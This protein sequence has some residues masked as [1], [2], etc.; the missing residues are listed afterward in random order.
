MKLSEV[1]SK[2]DN[3][4]LF[5]RQIYIQLRDAVIDWV[6]ADLDEEG[7]P[8]ADENCTFNGNHFWVQ[9]ARPSNVK[10][11]VFRDSA[12]RFFKKIE[13]DGLINELLPVKFTI[14]K[15]GSALDIEGEMRVIGERQ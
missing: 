11:A 14:S 3:Q 13:E 4:E 10:S 1:A 12:A 15:S 9:M 5:L 6:E 7:R 8:V 2:Q